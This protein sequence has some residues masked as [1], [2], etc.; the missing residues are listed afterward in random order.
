MQNSPAR[1][2]LIERIGEL[3]LRLSCFG[4]VFFGEIFRLPARRM[5]LQGE[6]RFLPI[7]LGTHKS[8]SS[9]ARSELRQSAAR[10]PVDAAG[11]REEH[12]DRL[13][14]VTLSEG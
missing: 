7:G 8:R 2:K 1:H 9:G 14:T 10:L 6:E 11:G 4:V 3:T 5:A 13:K 12:P